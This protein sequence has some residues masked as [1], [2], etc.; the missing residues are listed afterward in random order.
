MSPRHDPATAA[1]LARIGLFGSLPGETLG[2][3]AGRLRREE[4]S[5]GSEIDAS[6]AFVV[7]LRGMATAGGKMLRP[8][9]TAGPD[10]A[11]PI[12]AVTPV[13]VATCDRATYDEVVRP[14]VGA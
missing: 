4:R 7:L 12:R 3:L 11:E 9:A 6:E 14:L 2:K 10:A 5:A 13:T 1:E 8:G